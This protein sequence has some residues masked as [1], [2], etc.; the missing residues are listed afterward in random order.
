MANK[1][2]K[3]LETFKQTAMI[4]FDSNC[5]SI[6][7]TFEYGVSNSVQIH[8]SWHLLS[9]IIFTNLYL[10]S[11]ICFLFFEAN[12]FI[13]YLDTFFPIATILVGFSSSIFQVIT[14]P[15]TIGIINNFEVV[16]EKRKSKSMAK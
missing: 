2:L 13:E 10:C 9:T 4:P 8:I 5:A 14:R 6:A 12:A 3:I 15:K 1:K 16:I 11:L 7:F